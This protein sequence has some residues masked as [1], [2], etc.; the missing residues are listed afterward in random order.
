MF[1]GVEVVLDTQYCVVTVVVIVVPSRA[2][3]EKIGQTTEYAVIE[4]FRPEPPNNGVV[5][6]K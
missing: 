6:N 3:G 5:R 4:P 1:V 2:I